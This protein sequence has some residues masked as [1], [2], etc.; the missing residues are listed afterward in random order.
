MLRRKNGKSPRAESTFAQ[1]KS[2]SVEAGVIANLRRSLEAKAAENDEL[3][4]AKAALAVRIEE[5][6]EVVQERDEKL[7]D[8]RI[9]LSSKR[10]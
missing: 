4:K 1:G 6:R 10:E 2:L 3:L 7:L 8:L 9:Q 5:L